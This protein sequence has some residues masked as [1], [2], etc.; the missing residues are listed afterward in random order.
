MR[1]FKITEEQLKYYTEAQ[2]LLS[3]LVYINKNKIKGNKAFL[4]YDSSGASRHTDNL[5]SSDKL[6]TDKME[7]SNGDTYE[8]PLKNGIVSYNITSISGMEVMH[9]FKRY[10][11]SQKTEISAGGKSYE[12]EMESS[13][14]NKFMEFFK[15]KVWNVVKHCASQF[16]SSEK[17][18]KPVGISILPVPS[19]SNFNDKMA[20][21]LSQGGGLNGLPC[22]VI[23][24][25]L[26]VKDLRNLQRDEDFIAKN[27]E[28]YDNSM[29]SDN[30]GGSVLQNVDKA[31]N[32]NRAL[33]ELYGEADELSKTS[34]VL[35]NSMYQYTTASNTGKNS[36]GALKR[37]VANYRK[38]YD[39]L[40]NLKNK[41]KS[42]YDNPVT[43][44]R[45]RIDPDNLFQPIKGTKGPSVEKRSGIVWKAVAPY[46]QN[47]TCPATGKPYGPIEIYQYQ[48]QKFQIK[49]LSNAERMGLKNIYNPNKDEELVRQE[50]EKT[51]GTIFVIF[52]DNV[53][54]GATLSDI[55]YNAQQAGIE[56]IVPITFGKMAEKT[57]MGMKNVSQ[58]VNAK[59]EKGFNY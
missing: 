33:S 12:L 14:F 28:Y 8:V 38:Y 59:G 16:Q 39:S 25:Q 49:N 18:F 15:R 11:D 32:K 46:L 5:A 20:E 6:K 35:L 55:C 2:D 58:P 22:Q 27:K 34:T 21:L 42:A 23:N 50:V 1:T 53:S 43:G 54:G 17:G 30:T 3:E 10:W 51:K 24:S 26:F 7:Q 4:S 9:Y 31:V 40:F 48:R 29:F 44:S 52:D 13:E 57:R 19:S 56:H 45:S 36:E 47:E 41:L 37:L